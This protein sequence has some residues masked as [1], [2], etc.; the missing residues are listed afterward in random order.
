MTLSLVNINL[1]TNLFIMYSKVLDLRKIKAISDYQFNPIITDILFNKIDNI[2]LHYSRNTKKIKYIYDSDKLLLSFRPT[3]GFLTLSL[4]A[5]KKIVECSHIPLLRA[6]VMNDISEFIK[7]G[8]NVFCKHVIDIDNDLRPYDEI[9]IVNEE[10]ELLAI[11]RLVL[12]IPYI[13]S[14]NTGVAIKVRKGI[15]KSKL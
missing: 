15:Y 2:K 12:P 7:K 11:G 1:T 14:F 9:I 3:N 8:R 6:V 4:Y 10:D 13:K 5:A